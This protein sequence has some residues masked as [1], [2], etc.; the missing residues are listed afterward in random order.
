M[1][2]RSKLWITI[3]V[4]ALSATVVLWNSSADT[5][6]PALGVSD[7]R[8]QA[9]ALDGQ[10]VTVRGT[11][12]EGSIVEDGPTLVEFVVADHLEQLRVVYG[13]NP[14]DN[15]GVKEVVLQ[16]TL[17]T[18]EDG[19]PYLEAHAIQVGCASKY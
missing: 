10:A 9:A 3:L 18:G 2:R 13:Q 4:V 19:T 5:A 11:V 16:A 12:L 6:A 8:Y 1:R 15:F 7:A 17:V 14:P